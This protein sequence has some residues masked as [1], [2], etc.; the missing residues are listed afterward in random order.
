MIKK[1]IIYTKLSNFL[2]ICMNE[3]FFTE[4][5]DKNFKHVFFYLPFR[6]K[7]NLNEQ[8]QCQNNVVRQ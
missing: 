1:I 4:S 7:N 8:M 3:N 2:F 5:L 6:P